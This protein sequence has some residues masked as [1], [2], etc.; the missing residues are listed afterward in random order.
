MAR[1][2]SAELEIR[3]AYEAN[4]T[5]AQ[6]LAGAYERLVPIPRRPVR[7]KV[8]DPPTP[9]TDVDA[10]QPLWRTKRG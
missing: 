1:R 10:V 4:R 9:F 3:V 2:K 7:P 6:C 8:A 5:S